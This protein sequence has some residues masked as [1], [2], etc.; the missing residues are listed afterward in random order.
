MSW[1]LGRWRKLRGAGAGA[2]EENRVLGRVRDSGIRG[3]A[4]EVEFRDGRRVAFDPGA[5]T[6]ARPDLFQ[7]GHFSVFD[8]L[9]HLGRQGLVEVEAHFDPELN[10]SVVDSIAG[11]G[12]W[13][14]SA[15]YA[16][17]WPEKNVFRMDHFPY[18]DRTSIV[19]YRE[20]PEFLAG[21]Y[22]SFRAEGERKRR[23]GTVRIPE[24]R[25]RGPNTRLVFNDLEVRAHDLR[26]DVFRPG[27]VTAVDA[28]LSLADAGRLSYDLQWYDAIGPAA[29]V[30]SYWVNRINGDRGGGRS[31]FVYEEG[32]SE[33]RLGRGN[34]IHLP[35]DTRV[36]NAPDYVE[37][38]WI[39]L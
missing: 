38:F 33:F 5:V 4:A 19:F 14:Y 18:K 8:V 13:W 22:R 15:F 20:K 21:V 16:G 32:R 25:I 35:A 10:T 2:G 28:I 34:H 30:K 1:V 37:W 29:V 26:R 11:S 31:G 9:M 27:T 3:H 6:T 17:G 24:V 12:H 7:E 36:L 39:R 23:E